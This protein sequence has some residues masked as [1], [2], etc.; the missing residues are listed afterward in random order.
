[1]KRYEKA[2]LAAYCVLLLLVLAAY[3]LTGGWAAY[4]Q[5]S[6]NAQSGGTG[7]NLVDMRPLTTAQ[8]LAQLAVTS[9]EREYAQ[10]ALRLGDH[11]VDLVR[12][13]AARRL[14]PIRP[15]WMS[16]LV[17]RPSVSPRRAPR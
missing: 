17:H 12:R 7:P 4:F 6:R 2:V 8:T 15:P 11:L 5:Q 9:G 3:V 1:M 14:P 10:D 16:R 13:R